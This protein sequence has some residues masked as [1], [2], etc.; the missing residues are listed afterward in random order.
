MWSQQ[1]L[2]ITSANAVARTL[3]EWRKA[4]SSFTSWNIYFL[5]APALPHWLT[6]RS[7]HLLIKSGNTSSEVWKFP[8]PAKSNRRSLRQHTTLGDDYRKFANLLTIHQ[9]VWVRSPFTAWSSLQNSIFTR[10][11]RLGSEFSTLAQ[12]HLRW[13]NFL[14]FFWLRNVSARMQKRGLGSLSYFRAARTL[15]NPELS[16]YSISIFFSRTFSTK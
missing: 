1:S 7:N 8:S 12:I 4:N 15:N 2:F 9:V 5:P 3:F 13:R 14:R 16:T 6:I 11:L 10:V